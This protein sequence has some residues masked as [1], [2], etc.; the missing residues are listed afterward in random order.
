MCWEFLC[1]ANLYL[2]HDKIE[3]GKIG[4]Y[5]E[6]YRIIWT[7]L[8]IVLAIEGSQDNMNKICDLDE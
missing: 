7:I 4:R 6:S 2:E 1:V 8:S 5:K 3:Y